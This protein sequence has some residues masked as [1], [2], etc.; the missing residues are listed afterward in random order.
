MGDM[1]NILECLDLKWIID[2]VPKT[3]NARDKQMIKNGWW[4]RTIRLH[5]EINKINLDNEHPHN[6]FRNTENTC[7]TISIKFSI[8]ALRS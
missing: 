2:Y 6:T 7:P 5:Y 3:W 4:W 1:S 8:S